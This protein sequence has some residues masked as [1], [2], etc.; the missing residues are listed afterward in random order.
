MLNPSERRSPRGAADVARGR[1]RRRRVSGTAV[2]GAIEVPVPA[3]AGKESSWWNRR[4]EFD[5]LMLLSNPDREL[6]LLDFPS[7]QLDLSPAVSFEF[8]LN[9]PRSRSTFVGRLRQVGAWI[10]G[11]RRWESNCGRLLC[12][13][14]SGDGKVAAELCRCRWSVGWASGWVSGEGNSER[15]KKCGRECSA[16]FNTRRRRTVPCR[17]GRL[18][19]GLV[20]PGSPR[21]SME[22]KG[23]SIWGFGPFPARGVASSAD[24]PQP[25]DRIVRWAG[26]VGRGRVAGVQVSRPGRAREALRMTEEA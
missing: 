26:E 15:G 1:G 11:G 21:R 12:C 4:R 23:H 2:V 18:E 10:G 20:V 17:I 25:L 13:G 24:W 14:F 6:G 22:K 7:R 16:K 19:A 5:W 8:L 3:V 9:Q